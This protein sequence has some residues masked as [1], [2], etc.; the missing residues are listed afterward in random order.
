MMTP[1]LPALPEARAFYFARGGRGGMN[2]SLHGRDLIS[3]AD[4]LADDIAVL[5]ALAAELKAEYAVERRHAHPPL[6][7][8]TLAMLFQKPGL[9][10]RVASPRAVVMH[11][12][13]AHRGEEITSDV[14]DGPGSIIFEQSQNRLHAQEALLVELLGG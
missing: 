14:M 3:A 9:R 1:V 4:L 7:R 12:L 13:S 10:A 5:F 11:C 6:E 8:R 2:S